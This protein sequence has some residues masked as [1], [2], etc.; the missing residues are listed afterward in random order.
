MHPLVLIASGFV[1]FFSI[2]KLA[3][4]FIGEP[5]ANHI[6]KQGNV[7]IKNNLNT[8]R[9]APPP[10][11]P[12]PA[13][14]TE[15]RLR[16]PFFAP[17]EKYED[18]FISGYGQAIYHMRQAISHMQDQTDSPELHD[19]F[20]YSIHLVKEMKEHFSEENLES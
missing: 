8:T 1:I 12:R 3:E 7:Y 17:R 4:I 19:L 14:P 15:E 16:K 20:M 6:R 5:L 11:S 13:T 9:Q 10:P 18:S 2:M